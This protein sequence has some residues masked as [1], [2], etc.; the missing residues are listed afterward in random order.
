M[1]S[2]ADSYMI[3]QLRQDGAF[4]ID[5]AHQIGCSE[6]TV[7]RVLQRK[8][9]VTGRHR[10][11]RPAKLE[12][13][14]PFVDHRLGQQ[15]WN[16]EVIF[17]EIKE[18]GYTGGR[19]MLRRYIQPKRPLRESKKTVRFETAPGQQ[20]QH[21]WGECDVHIADKPCHISFAVNT[22]GYS[23]RFHV[24]AA[25]CQD[26]EHTYE[27]LVQSFRYFGG[28]VKEVLVDNQ[29]AAVLRHTPSQ[30][31]VFNPGFLQLAQHYGF[32]P[33]ACKPYRPR[34]KGKTER[35]VG[36]VKQNFFTRYREFD[37]LA[38]LNQ[39]LLLWLEHIADPR[40]LRQFQE[41]PTSRFTREQPALTPLPQQDFDTRYHDVRHVAWDGYIDVRGNRYSVP[42][43]YCGQTVC[44]RISLDNELSVLDAQEQC[45][46]THRLRESGWQTSPPHHA[47]LWQAVSKVEQ[48]PL[49]VYEEML[50]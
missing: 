2:R 26:A 23:R 16:A 30:R 29:K 17:Q 20:L 35:M 14:K 5:I 46:A 48:R 7:S 9:P 27:S 50:S 44:I 24:F 36:Y 34:T 38:H 28:S 39:Q 32:T 49:T 37:S 1:L 47:P 10:K 11:M 43:A 8:I 15:V 31:P 21:D 42:S 18:K 41:T 12:P 19:A 33:H 4:L 40:W 45:I 3:K 6:K 22:L 25:P 13:Y